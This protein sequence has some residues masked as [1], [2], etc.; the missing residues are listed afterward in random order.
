M[1]LN[2]QVIDNDIIGFS[3]KKKKERDNDIIETKIVEGCYYLHVY[4]VHVSYMQY[5]CI[6][7]LQFLHFYISLTHRHEV[8]R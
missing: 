1:L 6:Y 4:H 3:K 2:P 8:C 7:C 5:H